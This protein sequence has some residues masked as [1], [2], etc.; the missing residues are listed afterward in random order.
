MTTRPI[1]ERGINGNV[2]V[3]VAHTVQERIALARDIDPAYGSAFDA[4]RA[5]GVDVTTSILPG[6]PHAF[7]LEEDGSLSP[8]G[9][10]LVPEVLAW[11]ERHV[12]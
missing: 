10:A 1:A 6:E 12:G 11:L 2:S 8:Q 3:V 5:A 9:E 7:D 4:A